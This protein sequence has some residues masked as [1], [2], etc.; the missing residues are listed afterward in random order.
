V[1]CGTDWRG[2]AAVFHVEIKG[3]PRVAPVTDQYDGLSNT[4][5]DAC[6]K[7][8]AGYRERQEKLASRP[9]RDTPRLSVSTI[10]AV[11]YLLRRDDQ[12]ALQNFIADHPPPQAMKIIAYAKR[13]K[14]CQ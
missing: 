2:I 9:V 11:D 3:V 10:A 8:D 1:R 13:R 7:A 14:L 5:A 12:R 6:R 4:F